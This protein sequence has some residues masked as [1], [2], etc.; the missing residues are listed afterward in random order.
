MQSTELLD[1]NDQKIAVNGMMMGC[2]NFK[3]NN[4]TTMKIL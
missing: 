3:L 4:K 1:L 2:T